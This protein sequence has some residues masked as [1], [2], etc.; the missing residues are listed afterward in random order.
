[1]RLSTQAGNN[2]AAGVNTIVS[3]I[4]YD[5]GLELMH[6]LSDNTSVNITF[7]TLPSPGVFAGKLSLFH[8]SC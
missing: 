3:L 8:A 5:A 6:V 2:T 1:M 4:S 7:L